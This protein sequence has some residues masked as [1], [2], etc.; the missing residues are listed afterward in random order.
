M[1]NKVLQI[2]MFLSVKVYSDSLEDWV[3]S[4]FLVESS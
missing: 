1:F 4:G 3:R 2:W